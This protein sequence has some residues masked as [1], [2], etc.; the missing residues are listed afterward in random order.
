MATAYFK[1]PPSAARNFQVLEPRT[2]A[3][4]ITVMWERPLITGREDYYYNIQYSNPDNPGS[5]IQHNSNPLITTSPV[6]RYS[7]SGLQPQT[8]YTIELSVLNGVSDQDSAREEERRS[9]VI[10]TSGDVSKWP[11]NL[12]E[13]VVECS[14]DYQTTVIALENYHITSHLICHQFFTAPIS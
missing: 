14:S 3:N 8:R 1:G 6:V 2:R 5:F 11:R 4:T 12:F 13:S 7:V 10:A 9:E